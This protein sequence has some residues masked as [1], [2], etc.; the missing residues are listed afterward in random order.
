MN[1]KAQKTTMKKA[2]KAVTLLTALGVL[3]GLATP[4]NA[5][6]ETVEQV[7]RLTQQQSDKAEFITHVEKL[8]DYIKAVNSLLLEHLDEINESEY[9]QIKTAK[10]LL[11][12]CFDLIKRTLTED[13]VYTVFN[14]QV[15]A[16]SAQKFSLEIY[17]QNLKDKFEGVKTF[18]G[19]MS[20]EELTAL[21]K[22][23]SERW[24]NVV[25]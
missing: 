11:D 8:T 5:I 10:L 24:A 6:T 9:Q 21:S 13:E 19:L 4:L 2:N 14:T 16:F 17:A 3:S 1:N 22:S 20:N 25:S 23:V 7:Q 18:T 12:Y 15:R